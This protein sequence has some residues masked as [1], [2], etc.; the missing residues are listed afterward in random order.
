M[1]LCL[2]QLGAELPDQGPLA[3][4]LPLT[5]ELDE[6]CDDLIQQLKLLAKDRDEFLDSHGQS[7]PSQGPSYSEG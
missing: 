3:R 7:S 6:I 5:R 1:V 4:T 2:S